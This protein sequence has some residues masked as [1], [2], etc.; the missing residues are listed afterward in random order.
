MAGEERHTL[1][2]CSACCA[3]L[4]SIQVFF[5]RYVYNSSGS[6]RRPAAPPAWLLLSDGAEVQQL[7]QALCSSWP[8]E[9]SVTVGFW[10]CAPL[11]FAAMRRHLLPVVLLASRTR[12]GEEGR[13]GALG[14]PCVTG[15]ATDVVVQGGPGASTPL[16]AAPR[17]CLLAAGAELLRRS[18][19]KAPQS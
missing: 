19:W 2:G 8:R 11:R 5:H 17:A 14:S 13:R 16:L 4:F 7:R 12:R 15:S 18:P 9:G 10:W 6:S 3:F 1:R